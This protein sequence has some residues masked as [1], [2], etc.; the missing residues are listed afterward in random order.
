[1]PAY[2]VGSGDG[3]AG[4]PV[5]G[6]YV[7]PLNSEMESTRKVAGGFDSRIAHREVSMV[8]V[9]VDNLCILSISR[10]PCIGDR[11]AIQYLID[12]WDFGGIE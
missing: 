3:L 2:S 1:M 10:V 6:G 11:L 5:V 8:T 9:I 7:A 12:E 4:Y